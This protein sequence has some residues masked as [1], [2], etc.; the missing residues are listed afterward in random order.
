MEQSGTIRVGLLER[1]GSCQQIDIEEFDG[2][3][4]LRNTPNSS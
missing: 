3:L 1:A 4:Q 2:I